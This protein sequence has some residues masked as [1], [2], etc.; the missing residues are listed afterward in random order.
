MAD[1]K[2]DTKIWLRNPRD[3]NYPAAAD[4]LDLLLPKNRVQKIVSELKKEKTVLKKA[5]DILRASQLPLLP[6][7]NVHVKENIE[8][9]RSGKKLSPVLLVRN[10]R[11][12]VADGYHR[13]C[14]IYYL[15][16]DFDIPCRIT[17]IR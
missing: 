9:V 14:S 5:K 4:Y 17:D 11:L 8:K 1:R 6:A 10:E 12:I 7:D 16:E 13:V 15:S 2:L 3:S